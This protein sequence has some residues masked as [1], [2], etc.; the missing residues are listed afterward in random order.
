MIVCLLVARL[1]AMTARRNTAHVDGV[2]DR[3][4]R[5][6]RDREQRRRPR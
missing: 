3:A 4:E 1:R 2:Y 5:I 6:R